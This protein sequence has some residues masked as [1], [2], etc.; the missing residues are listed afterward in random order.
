MELPDKY[1]WIYSCANVAMTGHGVPDVY[2]YMAAADV[3]VHPSYR[4]GFSMVIQEAMAMA[5][6]VITTD[7]PGPSEVIEKDV[8]GILAQARNVE[9]L[10]ECMKWMYEH[11]E[12]GREMGKAGRKR[13]EEKFNRERMLRLTLEDREQ[14]LNS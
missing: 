10:Y 3:L 9:T 2:R 5:L 6:P 4:E 11:Q 13:C 1:K 12:K 7:I 8:T 14:I